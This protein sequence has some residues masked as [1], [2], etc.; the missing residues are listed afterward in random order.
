MIE[1]LIIT[2]LV[3][4]SVLVVIKKVFPSTANASTTS[5]EELHPMSNNLEL[6]K[7]TE[8][9]EKV[10]E[11]FDPALFIT[12]LIVSLVAAIAASLKRAFVADRHV[13]LGQIGAV[14]ARGQTQFAQRTG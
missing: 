3:L 9:L 5:N 6:M 11:Q 2:L 12:A 14:D 10:R 7:I 8:S 4:W 1:M 13:Q